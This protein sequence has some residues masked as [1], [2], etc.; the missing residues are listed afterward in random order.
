MSSQNDAPSWAE[1][2]G[3]GNGAEDDARKEAPPA[4]NKGDRMTKMKTMASTSFN[5]AKS[6]TATGAVKVKS[7]ATAGFGWLKT[8]YQKKTS[9]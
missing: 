7:G 1:Q 8:Q 3:S 9:K 6:A 5:K 4:E 2:W